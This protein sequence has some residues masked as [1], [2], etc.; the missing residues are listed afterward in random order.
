MTP[1]GKKS[2]G[3]RSAAEAD[4]QTNPEACVIEKMTV[5]SRSKL[6]L[7]LSKGGGCAIQLIPK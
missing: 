1:P 5:T 7:H 3:N 4:W 2:R 6:A